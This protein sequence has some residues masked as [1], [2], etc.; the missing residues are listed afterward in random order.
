MFLHTPID[1]CPLNWND[2]TVTL[3]LSLLP[4]CELNLLNLL[5]GHHLPFPSV[6]FDCFFAYSPHARITRA[7]SNQ[8]PPSVSKRIKLQIHCKYANCV[9][10]QNLSKI[11]WSQRK[12]NLIEMDFR[13]A[14]IIVI[15]Y[16]K[17]NVR[18]NIYFK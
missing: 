4:I 15:I 12:Q 7:A 5:F 17:N 11:E 13:S 1:G 16:W 2:E 14:A 6:V 18:K 8:V 10:Q 9:S 3:L